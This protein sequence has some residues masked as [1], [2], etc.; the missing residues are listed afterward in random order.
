MEDFNQEVEELVALESVLTR[1]GQIQ[2]RVAAEGMS[3]QVAME[4]QSLINGFNKNR[5]LAF[6]SQSPSFVAEYNTA[7]EALSTG[8]A[9]AL[10]LV[11][12][13]LAALIGRFLAYF[14]SKKGK[15]SGGGGGSSSGGGFKVT[16]TYKGK[17]Y[18][19]YADVSKAQQEDLKRYNEQFRKDFDAWA[20][21]AE[22]D[23]YY[24]RKDPSGSKAPPFKAKPAGK[25]MPS[26]PHQAFDQLFEEEIKNNGE[27][28]QIVGL[29]ETQDG[30]MHDLLND[31]AYTRFMHDAVNLAPELKKSLSA[32]Q[33][34]INGMLRDTKHFLD[35]RDKLTAES[36][37]ELVDRLQDAFYTKLS[38]SVQGKPYDIHE[39]VEIMVAQKHDMQAGQGT[40]KFKYSQLVSTFTAAT[41]KFPVKTMVDAFYD[42]QE[43]LPE[44]QS[45]TEEYADVIKG[46]ENLKDFDDWDQAYVKGLRDTAAK[47]SKTIK[48]I[49][50]YLAHLDS[51]SKALRRAESQV[52][53]LNREG[54][55]L[56]TEAAKKDGFEP[57]AATKKMTKE[58]LDDMT[59]EM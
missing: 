35:N 31:G 1:I 28:S 20:D 55:K 15:S 18:D 22:K 58:I 51:Y 24:D 49:V 11:L 12:I 5:P 4:A 10:T 19:N 42:A 59:V 34:H 54:V 6:Y 53:K 8:S 45:K 52:T 30:L 14:F 47:F 2:D 57:S 56:L 27:K 39:V 37:K 36:K 13:A 26:N 17:K 43:T 50:M 48:D 3:K 41:Q 46:V 21:R 16:W 40:K 38:V 7:L 32:L 9:P 33:G 44:I 23:G 25:S 29:L